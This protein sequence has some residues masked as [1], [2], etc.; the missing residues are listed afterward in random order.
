[1]GDREGFKQDFKRRFFR[2]LATLLPTIL[3][4]FI[5]LWIA[6]F[7]YTYVSEPISAGIRKAWASVIVQEKGTPEYEDVRA[8][9]SQ[10]MPPEDVPVEPMALYGEYVRHGY[11]SYYL[12]SVLSVLMAILGI[13]FLGYLLATYV[14]RA[15]WRTIEGSIT[16]LPLV[17][18]VYPQ[19]K[20]F[21]DF[22]FSDKPQ[23]LEANRVVLVEW[24][25]RGMWSIG[26]ATGKGLKDLNEHVGKEMVTV[27][28]PSAPTPFTGYCVI[29]PRED[30]FEVDMTVD[31]VLR[32][33]ISLGV[34]TPLDQTPTEDTIAPG[35]DPT[36]TS[37][38]TG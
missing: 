18:K 7:L 29:V 34:I 24:P 30:C 32:Y 38:P 16:A 2:G 20:Q 31:S 36:P 37:P 19:V 8:Y 12:I 23:P 11:D 14:G 3:T 33:V 26:L 10:C 5:L 13:Y 25:R 4:L 27:Y 35:V 6:N 22:M 9:V 21:T 17:R 15:L 28:L 1:M